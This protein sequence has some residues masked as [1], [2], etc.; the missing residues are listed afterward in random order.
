MLIILKGE[1]LCSW[2]RRGD[3]NKGI[4]WRKSWLLVEVRISTA[5]C[6]AVQFQ[7]QYGEVQVRSA[8]LY[9]CTVLC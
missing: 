4:N 7:I 6:A 2:I 3:T 8:R 1:L 9:R 5:L